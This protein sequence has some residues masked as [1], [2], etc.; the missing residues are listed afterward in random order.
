MKHVSTSTMIER[1]VGLLG[2]SDLD[3][4]EQTFVTS[5]QRYVAGGKVTD[6]TD[7]QVDRLDE[8]HAKHFG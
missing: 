1:L 3:A 6:L 2:T 5:L 8:L 7:K 4:W